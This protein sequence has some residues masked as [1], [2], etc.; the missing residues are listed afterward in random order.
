MRAFVGCVLVLGVAVIG[1][2]DRSSAKQ[3]ASDEPAESSGRP[4]D[5]TPEASNLPSWYLSV[6]ETSVIPDG[7]AWRVSAGDQLAVG[8]LV[9][10]FS[11]D[12]LERSEREWEFMASGLVAAVGEAIGAGSLEAIRASELHAAY[13]Y[14]NDPAPLNAR[15]VG[16]YVLVTGLVTPDNMDDLPDLYKVY[17]DEPYAHTPLFLETDYEFNFVKCHLI[18]PAIQTLFDWQDVEL[19]GRVRGKQ[20]L[21]IILDECI[22]LSAKRERQGDPR[23]SFFVRDKEPS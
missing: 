12:I 3:A 23:P 21:H 6:P 20:G 1:A 7:Y 22:V 13:L 8:E 19:I 4:S 9:A 10:R 11:D 17:E 15:Y 2:C 5:P 14:P 16:R 18:E